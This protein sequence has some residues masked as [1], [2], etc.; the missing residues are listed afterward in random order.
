LRRKFCWKTENCNGTRK[1]TQ[2]PLQ[3]PKIALFRKTGIIMVFAKTEE[4]ITKVKKQE[5]TLDKTK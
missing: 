4:T 3:C 2:K 5:K 1:K